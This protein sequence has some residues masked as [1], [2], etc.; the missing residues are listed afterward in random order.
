MLYSISDKH[1]QEIKIRYMLS[2]Y[3]ST[4]LV[5]CVILYGLLENEYVACKVLSP[6]HP[7]L[8]GLFLFLF[9][10]LT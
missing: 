5:I 7:S 8:P 3:T 10:V 4:V 9:F 1:V 6:L 2:L